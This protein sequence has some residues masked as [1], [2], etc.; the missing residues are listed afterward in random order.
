MMRFHF[1]YELI[2]VT[3]SILLIPDIKEEFQLK[4]GALSLS[5]ILLQAHIRNAAKFRFRDADLGEPVLPVH[6]PGRG[7]DL[8]GVHPQFAAAL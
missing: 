7:V 2:N 4:A 6:R 1:R 5:D 3:M 8:A